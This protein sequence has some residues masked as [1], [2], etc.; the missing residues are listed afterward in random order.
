MNELLNGP[1]ILSL[2]TLTMLEIVLGID[3]VIFVTIVLNKLPKVEQLTARRIW[4]LTGIIVRVILLYLLT[5]LVKYPL[6]L[7]ILGYDFELGDFVMIAGGLFLIVKTV[8]EIHQ[9]LEGDELEREAKE[10]SRIRTSLLSAVL[11]IIIIDLVFSFD[12]MITAVG[13]SRHLIVMIT[14]VVIAMI[15]MF[16]FSSRIAG[17]IH[18]HPTITMLA[19][20][21]LVL[22]GFNLVFEGLKPIHHQEIPQAY[23]YFS[24]AFSFGVELLNMRIRRKNK[25][26]TVEL[27]EPVENSIG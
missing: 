13:L 7:H 25:K 20:S 8:G 16:G 11:Q 26:K 2:L 10:T 9:K 14:A 22:V 3:N 17:Y 21:F 6:Q 24:M 1:A 12:S 5:W 15:I 19:L 18:R 27:N 4:M 23:L